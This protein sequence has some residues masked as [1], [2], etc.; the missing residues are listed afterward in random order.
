MNQSYKQKQSVTY[1]MCDR[2]QQ[3]TLSMLVNVLLNVSENHSAELNRQES[4]IREMGFNWI[5]LRYEFVVTRMPHYKEE[6]EIETFATEYNK[7]FTYREFIVRDNNQNELIKVKTTFALM[8]IENRKMTR[9]PSEVIN[10]YQAD[11]SKRIR[12]NAKPHEV[13]LIQ[14]VQTNYS[15]RYF[16][17]DANQHVNNS[18]YIEWL[19]DSLNASFM[20]SHQIQHGIITFDKEVK[21]DDTVTSKVSH[22]SDAHLYTDH[23]ILVDETIHASASFQWNER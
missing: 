15:V 7:L 16:D 6:V 21:E 2:T 17:I 14:A 5:V 1:Y 8:N 19:L 12:R 4:V 13:D 10:P 18:K 9:I 3:L 11:F 22:R 23:Q 20:A